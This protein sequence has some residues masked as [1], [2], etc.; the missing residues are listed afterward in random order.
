MERA[1]KGWLRGA[2]VIGVA[3]AMMAV[4]LLSPALAV[5][6]ATTSYVKGQVKKVSNRVN[7]LEGTVANL[8][9]LQYVVSPTVDIVDGGLG[10]AEAICP[11]GYVVTGGGGSSNT[12]E[13]FQLDSYPTHGVGFPAPSFFAPQGRTAWA[14]EWV[15]FG[16][17]LDNQIRA[18]A[19]CSRVANVSGNYAPGTFPARNAV[20]RPAG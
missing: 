16:D 2:V 1:R 14:F 20:T 8:N 12:A 15:D 5:R 13:G 3:G 19:I 4:A 7:A 11:S 9:Q 17:G 18:Y 6:L 10:Q